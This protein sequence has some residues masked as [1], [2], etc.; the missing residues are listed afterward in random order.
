MVAISV[1]S[2]EARRR[3][4]LLGID[5]ASAS[6][7]PRV[8]H[9]LGSIQ[10]NLGWDYHEAG[11]Y[12]LALDMFKKALAARLEEEDAE[13]T[14]TARWCV[15]RCYRSLNRVSEALRIQLA[16]LAEDAGAEDGY[17]HEEL[18]ELYLLQ[19]DENSSVTHFAEAWRLLS[20]DDWLRA[21]EVE[22]LDR[23]RRL[24]GIEAD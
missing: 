14:S 17:V 3:W 13:A 9:W 16:L 20:A 4:S 23:I 5:I 21:N 19:E 18:G 12:D 10:N 6:T 11:E 7:Q 2:T 22:R 8:R 1:D 24:A 15:A